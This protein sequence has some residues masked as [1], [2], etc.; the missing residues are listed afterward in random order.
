MAG[1]TL[2]DRHKNDPPIGQKTAANRHT[3]RPPTIFS[4]HSQDRT[5]LIGRTRHGRQIPNSIRLLSGQT[6]K[7]VASLRFR[8]RRSNKATVSHRFRQVVRRTQATLARSIRAKVATVFLN[9]RAIHSAAHSTQGKEVRRRAIRLADLWM[10]RSKALRPLRAIHLEG[11]LAERRRKRP[12]MIRLVD[13]WTARL[14]KTVYPITTPP[15]HR[16][17]RIR[18][19]PSRQLTVARPKQRLH[20]KSLRRL[21]RKRKPHRLHNLH[22]TRSMR[23]YW[24][25]SVSHRTRSI[26]QRKRPQPRQVACCATCSLD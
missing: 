4:I 19:Q 18:P 12:T 8:L 13:L 10:V 5:R 22:L 23:R 21:H 16:E 26:P 6:P 15:S 7:V 25:H 9:R 3:N 24:L 1:G 11:R 20:V 14:P 17:N 2:E